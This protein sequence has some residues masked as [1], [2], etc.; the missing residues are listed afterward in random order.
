MTPE[1]YLE[2]EP[3]LKEVYKTEIDKFLYFELYDTREMDHPVNINPI[4]ALDFMRHS[5][6]ELERII[7]KLLLILDV[8]GIDIEDYVEGKNEKP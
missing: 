7:S 1:E 2:L 5:N 4:N 3:E 8:N 6:M